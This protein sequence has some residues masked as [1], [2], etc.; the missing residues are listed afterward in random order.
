MRARKLRHRAR[1]MVETLR[2]EI[3]RAPKTFNVR[4]GKAQN[5]NCRS[6]DAARGRENINPRASRMFA[7]S[8]DDMIS[9]SNQVTHG[10]PY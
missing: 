9:T 4:H 8:F 7:T 6:K 5:V 2:P 3:V 1:V 10:N